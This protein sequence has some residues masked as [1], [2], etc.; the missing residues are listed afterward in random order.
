[1]LDKF[2]KKLMGD[3]MIDTRLEQGLVFAPDLDC[4]TC[5]I[6]GIRCHEEVYECWIR[7]TS[8]W[9]VCYSYLALIAPFLFLWTYFL[10]Q[11]MQEKLP[12]R[13]SWTN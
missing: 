6:H 8:R 2:G 9:A 5:L 11:K 7:E 4:P 10:H 13:N 3:L 1:M 12:N